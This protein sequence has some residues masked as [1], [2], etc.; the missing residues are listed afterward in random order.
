[1]E[2]KAETK[3]E[4]KDSNPRDRN[5]FRVTRVR[6]RNWCFT[7]NNYTEDDIKNLQ[8]ELEGY[9]FQ[10]ETGENGTKHLQGVCW[11]KN[12]RDF[13]AVKKLHKSAHWE[14]CQNLEAS[15][16][17]CS[18]EKTRTGCIF[19]S[20]DIEEN[21]T[22]AQWHNGLL[23]EDIISHAEDY[24]RNKEMYWQFEK[25]FKLGRSESQDILMRDIQ[26]KKECWLRCFKHI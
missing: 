24:N 9:V 10:E 23:I 26:V 22:V 2:N 5:T 4:P 14:K 3:Q 8:K 1:M 21:G 15:K 12:P 20:D 13:G 19:R 6:S 25:D 16:N 11:F 7:V 17:Y 18:K